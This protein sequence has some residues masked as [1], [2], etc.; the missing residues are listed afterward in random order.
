MLKT[1][2]YAQ[3]FLVCLGIGYLV[4]FITQNLP[5]LHG[6]I[7]VN[8]SSG[9]GTAYRLLDGIPH[10]HADSLDM[11]FYTLGFAMSSDRIFQMDKLRRLAQGR[12]SEILGEPA[13]NV[14]KAMRNYGFE[15]FAKMIYMNMDN[16][17]KGYLQDFSDGINDYPHYFSEGIEYWVLGTKF[18]KW[19]PEDSISIYT[20]MS[21]FL[22]ES[23]EV[24]R[25]YYFSKLQD[26]DLIEELLPMHPDKESEISTPVFTD[27]ELKEFKLYK[28]NAIKEKARSEKRKLFEFIEDNLQGELDL[29]E[30]IRKIYST[31]T[32]AS[33]CWA[34]SGE[35]TKN[36]KPLLVN[37]PHLDPSI[38]SHFYLAELNV[39]DEYAIGALLPGVPIFVSAR[40]KNIA[41]GVTTLNA[42][43]VDYFEEKI[44]G[45]KYLFKGKWEPL[46]VREEV[47]NIKGKDPITILVRSTHHGPVL[48]HAGS[49]VGSVDSAFL[50]AKTK[51]PVSI[52]WSGYQYENHFIDEFIDILKFKDM[53]Q[54]LKSLKNKNGGSFG[55][56]GADSSG[57]I[58]FVPHVRYP[59]RMDKF[60]G[61]KG[62]KPGWTG[63]YEWQGFED[64]SKY[65]VMINPKKGYV[66][67]AN[68]R[69][70]SLNTES[71]IGS[72]NPS[73]ARAARI[74]EMLHDLIHVQRKKVDINDMKTML[75][76]TV[77][78]F[79][80]LKTPLLLK[81][82]EQ[83]GNLEK[84]IEDKS[85]LP[86]IKEWIDQLKSWNYRFDQDLTQPTLFSLWEA[87]L[88]DNM[89]KRQITNPK[90][91]NFVSKKYGHDD[92]IVK[93]L[94]EVSQNP[95]HFS[96]YC[97]SGTKDVKNACVKVVVGGLNFIYEYLVPAGTRFEDQDALFGKWHTVQY[98]YAPFTN[99]FLRYFFDRSDSDSGSKHTINVGSIYYEDFAEKGLQSS[100][101]PIYRMVV[102]FGKDED[103]Q[104]CIE[105]GASENILGKY[106][107]YNLHDAHMSMELV[108]MNFNSLNTSHNKRY[109]TIRF[110]Y[111]DWYDQEEERL[112]LLEENKMNQTST[113]TKTDDL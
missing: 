43:N 83:D 62:I 109:S 67:A 23:N 113:D 55:L 100:H 45:D 10:V 31:G 105:T 3:L 75:N 34:I 47:I 94:E 85:R 64:F 71:G 52:S 33:N 88:F 84:Y 81:I 102:D 99:S 7:H 110:I 112:R 14:D 40:T 98:N 22:S 48:D 30:E 17:T 25:D 1:L 104:F 66:F 56:C 54:V 73:T 26:E 49:V 107:Y 87:Y 32:G 91:R 89:F 38:P 61:E 76:D 77:D 106:F 68:G 92:F 80:K 13:V 50:H 4:I 12:L 27:E 39:N 70:T 9:N 36:G 97:Q 59:K 96:K 72:T 5:G 103:N 95:S 42:D 11:S 44:K 51:D 6:V 57:N 53:N 111:K 65:P 21:F 8:R 37:D 58:A 35:H 86:Q 29:V 90:L 41:F 78:I 2:L 63:K 24:T 46:E 15:H 108:P 82:V 19:K 74:N 69:I 79:A 16:K 20:F 101:T 93:F 60:A 28:K 18:D